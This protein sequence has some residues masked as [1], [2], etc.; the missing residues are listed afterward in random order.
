MQTDRMPP[1]QCKTTGGP[2]KLAAGEDLASQQIQMFFLRSWQIKLGLKH[3]LL[4]DLHL[5]G[6]KRG[7]LRKAHAALSLMDEVFGNILAKRSEYV[8]LLLRVCDFLL[9]Q[10]QKCVNTF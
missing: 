10:K 8:D 5:T 4:L 3:S 6:S 1:A 2:N 9:E 7:F